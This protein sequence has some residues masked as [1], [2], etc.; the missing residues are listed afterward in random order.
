[1][2]AN[3][4]GMKP[5]WPQSSPPA[6]FVGFEGRGPPRFP[7]L[8]ESA[9]LTKRGKKRQSLAAP[10][11]AKK[12]KAKGKAKAKASSSKAKASKPGPEL[13]EGTPGHAP[14]QPE[15]AKGAEAPDEAPSA[16]GFLEELESIPVATESQHPHRKVEDLIQDTP[17]FLL[18]SSALFY[19]PLHDI[20]LQ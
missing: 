1:M 2:L 18:L 15:E 9:Q 4:E 6:Y 14:G 13:A 3:L 17:M 8:Q 11:P 10:K 5:A 20:V 19:L 16:P 12:A 7:S